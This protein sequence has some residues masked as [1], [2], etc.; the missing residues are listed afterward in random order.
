V[1]DEH[2][3]TAGRVRIG[4]DVRPGLDLPDTLFVKLT[5]RSAVQRLMMQVFALGRREVLFYSA[6]ASDAP[7][8]CRYRNIAISV[9]LS[10]LACR[11]KKTLDAARASNRRMRGVV[12]R[13]SIQRVRC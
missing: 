8:S 7:V 3:G 6:V 4:I 10:C 12:M 5:P 1:L 13:L 9:R 2:H 11:G